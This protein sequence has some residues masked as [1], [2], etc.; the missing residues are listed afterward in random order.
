MGLA[1]ATQDQ[2]LTVSSFGVPRLHCTVPFG[3]SLLLKSLP[4]LGCCRRLYLEG[5][6]S[7]MRGTWSTSCEHQQFTT[8]KQFHFSSCC[9]HQSCK[10]G[11]TTVR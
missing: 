4:D 7:N 11:L 6:E 3:S 1:M 8:S 10:Q 9:V 2:K 5:L